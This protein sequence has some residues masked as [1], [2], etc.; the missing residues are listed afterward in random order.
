[1]HRH[2]LLEL[3]GDVLLGV[4]NAFFIMLL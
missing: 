4:S 3:R 1:L 2:P